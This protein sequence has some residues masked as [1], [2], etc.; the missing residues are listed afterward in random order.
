MQSNKQEKTKVTT[1]LLHK[2]SR[3]KKRCSGLNNLHMPVFSPEY[4]G[5]RTEIIPQDLAIHLE[6]T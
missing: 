6:Y 2:Q 3:E 1:A 4:T 5:Q